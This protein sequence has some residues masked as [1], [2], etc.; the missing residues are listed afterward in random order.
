MGQAVTSCI[1][2]TAT[3]SVGTEPVGVAANPRTNTI[4]VANSVDNTVSVISGQVNTVTAT[5]PVGRTPGGVAVKPR[6][7]TI[8]LANGTHDT[9]S[10]VSRP[11]NAVVGTMPVAAAA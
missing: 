9:G 11:A 1:K 3:I 8:Y 4:Y 2:I 5:V 10:V 7:N 6:T